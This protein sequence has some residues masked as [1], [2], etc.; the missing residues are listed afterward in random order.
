MKTNRSIKGFTLVEIMIVVIIIGLLA[1]MAIPIFRK[2]R[3]ASQST[4]VINNLRQLSSAAQQYFMEYGVSTANY[5]DLVGAGKQIKYITIVASE[6]YPLLYNQSDAAVVATSSAI[7][8][9][10]NI[11]FAY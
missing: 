4:T 7:E 10:P 8:G 9:K 1:A 3:V 6:Q 5:S 2:I 11:T